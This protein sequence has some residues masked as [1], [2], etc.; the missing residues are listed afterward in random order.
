MGSSSSSDVSITK[1]FDMDGKEVEPG[2]LIQI[3]RD[4]YQHWAVYVGCGNVVHLR[5]AESGAG[6]GEV[7]KQTL[8][9]VVEKDNWS[10]NNLLDHEYKRH[11]A[12]DIVKEACSLAI[13]GWQ[14]DLDTHNCEH[15][16][17]EMRYGK[18]ES[19]QG[20]KPGD[21]I[22]IFRRWYQHWAVYVGDGNIV[23]FVTPRWLAR[24]G[25]V[26]KQKL[27]DVLK[28]N[29]WKVNNLLDHKYRPR[30]AD[31]I[32]R[33]A[34]SLADTERQYNLKKSNC[35]HFATEMRYGKAESQQGAKPGDLIEIF[36][37]WYQHWAV[38]VGDGNIVHL[39]IPRWL[40]RTGIVWKQKLGDVLKNNW[41]NVNNL[42]DHKYRPRPAD[43]I[44]FT[45]GYRT[46]VQPEE[47]KL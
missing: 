36:R 9:D 23:H 17:T 7:L 24:T 22:E 43:D 6:K 21:L 28:N 35:E 19:R 18:P 5:V 10:V 4:G 16:A 25:V 8:E 44:V 30:P 14:Y 37:R 15:F 29:W 13:T 38:Y 47:V 2:D 45:G 3:F 40:A 26:W 41:W 20:A 33:D 12:D 42:L 46:A 39:T 32:V 27:G 11:P 31:D 34:C 1:Y